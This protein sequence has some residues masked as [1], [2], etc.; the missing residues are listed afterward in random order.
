[1]MFV[2]ADRR[3]VKDHKKNED[4]RRTTKADEDKD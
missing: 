1:M 4:E 3:E 2:E